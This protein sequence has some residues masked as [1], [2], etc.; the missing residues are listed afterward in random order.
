MEL[1]DDAGG[2]LAG[3]DDQKQRAAELAMV[4]ETALDVGGYVWSEEAFRAAI[5]ISIR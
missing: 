5:I 4:V 1:L 3:K 2:K